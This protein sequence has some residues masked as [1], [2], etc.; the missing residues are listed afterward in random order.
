MP[1]AEK[2]TWRRKTDPD[3]GCSLGSEASDVQHVDEGPEVGKQTDSADHRVS[4]IRMRY[5]Q[6]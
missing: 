5:G 6:V 3:Q 1:E 2:R 4:Q